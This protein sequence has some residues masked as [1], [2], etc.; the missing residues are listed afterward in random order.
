MGRQQAEAV[1]CHR[2]QQVLRGVATFEHHVRLQRPVL[3]PGQRGRAE[4]T[5]PSPRRNGR[6]VRGMGLGDLHAIG[7]GADS[8]RVP[9]LRRVVHAIGIVGIRVVEPRV[10]IPDVPS[11]QNE[12]TRMFTGRIGIR[13]QRVHGGGPR[14]RA[15]PVAVVR[16]RN[17][18][19]EYPK[20]PRS[21][22]LRARHG[23]H[24]HVSVVPRVSTGP[25]PRQ[26]L[27]RF[28]TVFELHWIRALEKR[29][30]VA[31]ER[32]AGHLRPV[33]MIVVVAPA[34]LDRVQ[35][36]GIECGAQK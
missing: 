4:R 36:A 24:R 31:G 5:Q 11:R 2:R 17:G 15:A 13:R 29:C 22:S 23:L 20:P 28:Q 30:Q 21:R 1:R 35:I 6:I 9:C 19:A 8:Q 14:R 16:S 27:D 12:Q 3:L 7:E 18:H 26:Q 25:G 10:G 32:H 34:G 33:A